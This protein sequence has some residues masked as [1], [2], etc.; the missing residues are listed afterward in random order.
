MCRD[1]LSGA[2]RGEQHGAVFE[3]KRWN[4]AKKTRRRDWRA[5]VQRHDIRG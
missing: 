5:G 3:R 1:A 2:G 4:L